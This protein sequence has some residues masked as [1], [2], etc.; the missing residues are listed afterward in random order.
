MPADIPQMSHAPKVK[1]GTISYDSA[2]A[3][4]SRHPSQAQ[5]GPSKLHIELIAKQVFLREAQQQPAVKDEAME[6]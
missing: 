6:Q 1:T 2:A 3:G 4:P 5:R